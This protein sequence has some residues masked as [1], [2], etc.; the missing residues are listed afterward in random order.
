MLSTSR[1][2]GRGG[3]AAGGA[4]PRRRGGR[5]RHRGRDGQRPDC[6]RDARRASWPPTPICSSGCWACE[7]AATRRRAKRPDRASSLERVDRASTRSSAPAI[8]ICRRSRR[9]PRGPAPRTVRSFTQWN[10]VDPLSETHDSVGSLRRRAAARGGRPPRRPKNRAD[11][12]GADARPGRGHVRSAPRMSRAPSTPRAASCSSS[13]T[14]SSVWAC[15]RSPSTSP[16][17]ASRPPR[18]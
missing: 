10:A 1:E 14:A 11:S 4:E 13:A 18:A 17:R 7:R 12:R 3:D 15:A 6:T 2:P 8:P 16:P 9:P 5:C